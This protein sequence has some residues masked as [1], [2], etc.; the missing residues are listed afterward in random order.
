MARKSTKKGVINKN[1]VVL[2]VLVVGLLVTLVLLRAPEVFRFGSAALD[3][4]LQGIRYIAVQGR[5]PATYT[6]S[7]LAIRPCSENWN[8]TE[9]FYVK[10]ISTKNVTLKY[11]LDCW[12]ESKC[13]DKRDTLTLTPGQEVQLGLGKPCSRWQL[14]LNWTGQSGWDWGGVVEVPG[15]CSA[16]PSPVPGAC[17]YTEFVVQ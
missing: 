17:N 6:A 15:D 4:H 1:L 10:N 7:P 2:I 8:F 12:D 16:P 3:P 5:T 14:D 9:C 13:T 11:L